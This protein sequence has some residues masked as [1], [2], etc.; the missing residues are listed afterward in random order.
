MNSV[1]VPTDEEVL[2]ILHSGTANKH[3]HD[4]EAFL[5]TNNMLGSVTRV[6]FFNQEIQL[7]VQTVQMLVCTEQKVLEVLITER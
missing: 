7:G 6:A 5:L 3:K 1:W 4:K 2:E